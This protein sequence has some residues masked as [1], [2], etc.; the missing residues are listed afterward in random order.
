MVGKW[1][2]MVAFFASVFTQLPVATIPK[3]DRK[4]SKDSPLLKRYDGSLIVAYEHKSFGELT[5][6]LSRLEEVPGKTTQ[7]NNRVHEPKKKKGSKEPIPE[8][9]T[10]FPP[11][12][13]RSR[14]CGTT[15][16]RSRATEERSSTNARARNAVQTPGVAARAAAET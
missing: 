6:P 1:V 8:S 9:P 11:T 16:T 12:G 4:G 10:S 7:Q 13:P 5:L 15:R 3:A 2:V 14:P